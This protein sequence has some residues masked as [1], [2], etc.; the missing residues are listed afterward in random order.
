MLFLFDLKCQYWYNYVELCEVLQIK[1]S[2]ANNISKGDRMK[3]TSLLN[4]VTITGYSFCFVIF[5]VWACIAMAFALGYYTP[6]T[7]YAEEL[8]IDVVENPNVEMINGFPVLRLNG[9]TES[10]NENILVDSKFIVSGGNKQEFDDEGNPIEKEEI[11]ETKIKL[12]SSNIDVATVPAEANIGEPIEILVTKDENGNN[13]GG[14]CYINVQNQQGLYMQKPLVVFVDIPVSGLE[15]TSSDMQKITE[16]VEEIGEVEK[17]GIY[18]GEEADVTTSFLPAKSQDPTHQDTLEEFNPYRK[19]AKVVQY[20]LDPNS[21][22]DVVELDAVTGHIKALKAGEV[23]IIVKTLKTYD[24]IDFVNDFDSGVTEWGDYIPPEYLEGRYALHSYIVKVNPVSLEAIEIDNRILSLPLFQTKSFTIDQLGISLKASNGSNDYFAEQLKDLVLTSGS[25]ELKVE[26][27]DGKWELTVLQDPMHGLVINI[28]LPSNP[29]LNAELSEFEVTQDAV[30]QLVFEGTSKT[31]ENIDYNDLIEISIT[32]NGDQ[33]TSTNKT[34]DWTNLVEII[35]EL[36]KEKSTYTEVK[37][38]AIGAYHYNSEYRDAVF[39]NEQGSDIIELGETLF[40]NFGREIRGEDLKNPK[41]VEILARGNIVLKAYVIKTDIDGTPIDRNGQ[42]ILLNNEGVPVDAEGNILTENIPTFVEAACSNEVTFRI[43]EKLTQLETYIDIEDENGSVIGENQ[44]VATTLNAGVKKFLAVNSISSQKIKL[45]SNSPG[46]LF[47]AYNNH[48]GTTPWIRIVN[49]E[50]LIYKATIKEDRKND[51]QSYYIDLDVHYSNQTTEYIVRT[52]KIEYYTGDT[53][54]YADGYDPLLLLEIYIIEVPVE[55][56]KMNVNI[57]ANQNLEIED[58]DGNIKNVSYYSLTGLLE[59]TSESRTIGEGESAV[60]RLEAKNLSSKWGSWNS[61][62]IDELIIS[63]PT[64]VE[65]TVEVL[66][67]LEEGKD[68]LK[69]KPL[70]ISNTGS[71]LS[72]HDKDGNATDAGEIIELNTDGDPKYKLKIKEQNKEFCVSVIA[73]YQRKVD[74]VLVPIKD[75]IY[76]K[77]TLKE[78]TKESIFWEHNGEEEYATTA[79]IKSLNQVIDPTTN[80][81]T[82]GYSLRS[83]PIFQMKFKGE[84]DADDIWVSS[85]SQYLGFEVCNDSLAKVKIVGEKGD[86]KLVFANQHQDTLSVNINVFVQ[87][88]DGFKIKKQYSIY[89]S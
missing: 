89:F 3:K 43:V 55:A 42:K 20:Q 74:D 82:G 1:F 72:L 68:Y 59:Y 35:P 14:F 8:S 32:K 71:T 31:N 84:R 11:T 79:D 15:T 66:K 57:P 22:G 2:F 58:D 80:I 25:P 67:D 87:T 7:V 29:D 47:D 60:S 88:S 81:V 45:Q 65:G 78:S 56:I 50:P 48:E 21:P 24:D 52:I 70:K 73:T 38:F 34:F 44:L 10:D 53:K 17:F 33:I 46:A 4:A 9:I 27:R 23:T 5:I 18:E 49:N 54:L 28:S 13:K 69:P 40:T 19:D 16:E 77:G 63:Q 85:D 83:N 41:I 26:K 36:G 37:I 51:S 39:V 75:T 62:N 6:K 12:T 86:E 30:K 61:T 76:V 64:F